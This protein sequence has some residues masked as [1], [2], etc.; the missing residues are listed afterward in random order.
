MRASYG[1]PA[2]LT[3]R[4][5]SRN[6]FPRFG[7]ARVGIDLRSSSP[8]ISTAAHWRGRIPKWPT[9]AD[10][11][12]AGLRLRWFESSSYHHFSSVDL[13]FSLFQIRIL[14]IQHGPISDQRNEAAFGFLGE[15]RGKGFLCM[16]K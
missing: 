3:R 12:S 5:D 15:F 2:G 6:R 9:G 11:K 4:G 14:A 10:C 1:M 7:V 8:E 16:F 13:D